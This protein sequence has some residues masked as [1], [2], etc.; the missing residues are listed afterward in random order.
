MNGVPLRRVNQAYVIATTTKVDVAGVKLP[1]TVTDAFFAAEAER[2][3]K[4]ASDFATLQAAAESKSTSAER[5]AV[6]AGVDAA[7]KLSAE[8]K[9]YLKST[10][11]LRK[12]DK[13]HE[14]KW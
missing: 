4:K 14:M 13:P 9:A 11:S 5:K 8:L 10:F 3:P 6:Q 7:I 12:G 1:A 2:K